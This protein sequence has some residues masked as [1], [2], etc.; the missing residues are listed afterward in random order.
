MSLPKRLYNYTIVLFLIT[1][2]L[3]IE[4]V[5]YYNNNLGGIETNVI[6]G[7]QRLLLGQPL[8]QDPA[9]GSYAVLQYTP[10]YYVVAAHCAT[11]LHIHALDVQGIYSLCRVLALAFNL[12]TILIAAGIIRGW[13]IS[14]LWSLTCALPVL[15]LL[16][17][18]YYTRGDSMHLLF[19]VAAAGCY[20]SFLRRAHRPW[21]LAA[22]LSSAA[23]IM[24][25]QSGVLAVGIIGC[26]LF[27]S[28]GR[29]LQAITFGI[30]AMLFCFALAMLCTGGDLYGLYRNACLG[31]KNGT[32]FSYLYQLFIS[33]FYTDMVPCYLLAAA[34]A[35]MGTA[36]IKDN[37]YSFLVTGIV[38][39]WFFAVIT[40]VK[41]GS[42]NNYFVEFLTLLI[43]ALPCLFQHA[44]SNKRLLRLPRYDLTVRSL[45][46]I[47]LFILVTSK[48]LGFFTAMY[49]DKSIRN[50]SAEYAHEEQLYN[51][52]INNL[53]LQ[54]GEHILFTER[55]F[56]D[57]LF[58]EYSVMPTKDVVSETYL[59]DHTTFNYSAY[60]AGQNN[61]LVRYIVADAR[62]KDM[63]RWHEQ[64]PFM[65]PDMTKFDRM[66]DTCG[67]SI[68]RYS[69]K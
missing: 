61:G 10:L 59:A 38:M 50:N 62:K 55:N 47:A 49:L 22:A 7:I 33:Q 23:C 14:W 15:I 45:G 3:R 46:C 16:T 43:I 67:Y 18:H 65:H 32:D 64:I 11:L 21:L 25:K 8:Y 44:A 31:L 30:L 63:D 52:F 69:I 17:S 42:S 41:N 13:G 57:N 66:V 34:M 19:F 56:L 39:S 53:H 48:T 6:Y 12:L 68:Y 51:Y 20:V 4:L 29:Y 60:E 54:K 2:F 26:S 27:F 9:S 35:W 1:L 5:G 40:G 36:K 24:T 28:R 58:I 37:S